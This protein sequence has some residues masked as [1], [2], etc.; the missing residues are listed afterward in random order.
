MSLEPDRMVFASASWSNVA[1]SEAP[2]NCI[3]VPPADCSKDVMKS[4][5]PL[6]TRFPSED[7]VKLML[8]VTEPIKN[9]AAT[10]ACD[11][12]PIRLNEPLNTTLGVVVAAKSAL[13]DS[14]PKNTTP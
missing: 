9:P 7:W 14:V 13:K 12:V 3:R 8:P 5:A 2:V 6:R 4:C 11:D 1:S 10:D